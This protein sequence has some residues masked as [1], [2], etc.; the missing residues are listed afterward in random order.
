MKKILSILL[1]SF[2]STVFSENIKLSCNIDFTKSYFSK[3]TENKHITDI[4]TITELGI[5][6]YIRFNSKDLSS[7]SIPSS[8]NSFELDNSDLNK[9]DIT[10]VMTLNSGDDILTNIKIDRNVGKIWYSSTFTTKNKKTIET[11]GTGICE[12]VNVTKKKF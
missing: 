2:S 3:S 5:Y 7:V 11:F 8:V 4:V 10:N 1:L 6:K 9:W 12:K